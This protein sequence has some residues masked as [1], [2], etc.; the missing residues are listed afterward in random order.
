MSTGP[1]SLAVRLQRA[2]TVADSVA[3]LTEADLKELI[4]D[5][6]PLG[7]GI[8]GR[9]L[10]TVV[11]GVEVF[12]KQV[13]LTDLERR[14]EHRGS[15][16]NLFGLPP[17]YQYGAGSA[18]FG[19]WRELAAHERTT[20]WVRTGS[21]PSFPL[22]YGHRVLEAAPPPATA[23]DSGQDWTE[24]A[25]AARFW[26]STAVRE[27]V[28]ALAGASASV[29]LFLEYLP[30]H[31]SGWFGARMAEGGPGLDAACAMLESDPV[32]TARL[33]N[34]DG[35]HHFDAHPLNLLTDGHRVYIADLGLATDTGY[36]LGDDERAFLARHTTY[37]GAYVV[38]QLVNALVRGL[39]DRPTPSDRLDLLRRCAGG[40]RLDGIRPAAADL[41]T[42]YAPLAVLT[43][44]FWHDLTRV[45]RRTR[46]PD[47]AVRA[48]GEAAG[49]TL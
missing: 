23:T 9:T 14:P 15:T 10:L 19:V 8:G 2:D 32:R 35:L 6:T 16:A 36:D 24:P 12:V 25:A 40:E 48:A 3:D 45:S 5:A 47:E 38:T 49:L 17:Y 28:E 34:E 18:G 33:M 13:R 42:R 7:S 46:Y 30:G 1:A 20:A 44:E 26:G 43:N 11:G 29:L 39:T 22:L 31:V 37:D 41:I 21:T 4:R 27:R